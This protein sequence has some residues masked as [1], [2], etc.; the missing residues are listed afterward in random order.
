MKTSIRILGI[1]FLVTGYAFAG[2][3]DQIVVQAAPASASTATSSALSYETEIRK[4]LGKTPVTDAA[5]TASARQFFSEANTVMLSMNQH[6]MFISAKWMQFINV[7]AGSGLNDQRLDN[8]FL[9]QFTQEDFLQNVRVL[10]DVRT[11]EESLN[12]SIVPGTERARRSLNMM[13][14]NYASICELDRSPQSS[15]PVEFS[16]EMRR[17]VE[18][19]TI[20]LKVFSEEMTSF[21]TLAN[22]QR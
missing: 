10:T 6:A 15:D 13:F 22:A 5:M 7:L 1:F 11:V 16:R 17:R 19:F 9:K 2:D 3:K 18:F 14:L 21:A 20:S 8:V 4:L 12:R